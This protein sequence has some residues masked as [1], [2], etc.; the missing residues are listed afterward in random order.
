[1]KL[2][3][4]EFIAC[5]V[6]VI[7]G[8]GAGLRAAIQAR[9]KGAS[10]VLASKSLVGLGN[11]TAISKAAFSVVM[12]QGDAQDSPEVHVKDTL[13]G[14][15]FINDRRLV[16]RV[17]RKMAEEVAFLQKC[18]VSFQSSGGRLSISGAPGHSYPR[19][20]YGTTRIGTDFT[21]PLKEY[22]A[23]IGVRLMERVFITRLLKQ[24]GQVVGAA[25]FDREGHFLVFNARSTVL[26]TG[27]FGQMYRH[28]NNAVGMTGDGYALAFR[29]GAPLRDMEFVQFYPTTIG[30][31]ARM[32]L[33]EV[34]VLRANA[35]IHNSRGEN[36]LQKHGIQDPMKMTR[37]RLTR[38]ITR[39]IMAG[40]DVEGGV[41]M[42]L[43][44]IPEDMLLK[45]RPLL[46]PAALSGKRE[47]IVSPA[48][49]FAMGGVVTD[50]QART[51]LPG[52]FACGEVVGGTHG[53]NRLAG[54]ALAEVFAMGGIAGDSAALA[55]KN[56]SAVKPGAAMVAAERKRLESRLEGGVEN[57]AD[58]IRS[59][60]ETAWNKVGIIRQQSGLDDALKG[61]KDIGARARNAR[62]ADV[63]GLVTC[64][65]LDNMLLVAEMVARAALERQESRG[66]H[67]RDDYPQEDPA[68]LASLWV[69]N[70]RGKIILEKRPVS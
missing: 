50:E 15:R 33:Y 30:G 29:T 31:G 53:A 58:L 7:G 57:P 59:L 38:A 6:L 49:H 26:A 62:A 2:G 65:E 47:F 37:D 25:G 52:L 67:F 61:I 63:K 42:D 9:E 22:A 21:K 39:E 68:W 11:N 69:N 46:P 45:V 54:N 55:A 43:S 4:P 10:V 32:L 3:G 1:M 56:A 5:D 16:E 35:I 13:E 18:G 34:F 66:A 27:G 19:H 64:L 48:A 17:A 60:K 12:S 70:Q 28:T 23:K 20:V 8:G 41:V 40:N 36:V 51:A 44:P 14:G 24:V